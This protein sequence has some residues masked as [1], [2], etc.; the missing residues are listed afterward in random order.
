MRWL[1]NN[2]ILLLVYAAFIIAGSFYLRGYLKYRGIDSW[3]SVSAEIV[4]G[5]GSLDSMPSGGRYGGSSTTIDSRYVEFQYSVDGETYRS[6]TATADGGGLPVSIIGEPWRAF[7]KP[8][9]P[10]IAVLSPT[11]YRGVGAM[12][13]AVFSGILVFVH[14]WCGI[15]DALNHKQ[16]GEQG[17]D[18]DAEEAV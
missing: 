12:V 14:V 17:G 13:T 1:I 11:P 6:R 16:K 8:S 10:N 18:G 2:S 15:S 5:G 3:P 7:Y 4:G 9:S